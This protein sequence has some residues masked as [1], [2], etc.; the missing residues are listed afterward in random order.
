MVSFNIFS[1]SK[2][3]VLEKTGSRGQG[4]KG[5]VTVN[6]DSVRKEKSHTEN[7]H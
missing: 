3:V 4:L 7:W 5:Q 1:S 2:R 6:S